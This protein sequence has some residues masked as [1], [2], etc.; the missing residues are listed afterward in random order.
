MRAAHQDNELQNSE[1]RFFRY[2]CHLDNFNI[3]YLG[4]HWTLPKPLLQ[5]GNRL[6]SSL[7]MHLYAPIR[8]IGR[9]TAQ[10]Q[11]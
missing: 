6:G 8:Q 4:K 1:D 3:T 10:T 5:L 7:R 2:R 11:Q 9:I